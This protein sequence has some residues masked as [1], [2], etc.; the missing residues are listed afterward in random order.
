MEPFIGQIMMFGGSF[1][2]RGWA[3]CDGQLL[4]ISA[5]ST[6]FSI[7]GTTYGGDGRT[8][9]ALPDLRGRGPIHEGTGPG[10][11]LVR[12]GQK[13]GLEHVTLNTTQIPSHSHGH[14]V[15]ASSPI[16]RGGSSSTPIGN[17]WAEEGAYSTSK[18]TTM[19]ADAISINN[20][21]GSR[22]HENRSPYLA[23]NFIVALTGIY[24]SRS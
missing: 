5:Y 17:Y 3:F 8:T 1:A 16:P 10:L 12:L 7:L 2:P 18:N 14:S 15:A 20:T 23:V 22:S 6:L 24:P 21:G 4:S 9:F 13:G 11:S 19:A